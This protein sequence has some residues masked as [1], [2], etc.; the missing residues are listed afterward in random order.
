MVRIQYGSRTDA[1]L[2]Q[3]F[4]WQD[5]LIHPGDGLDWSKLDVDEAGECSYQQ[6]YLHF[7]RPTDGT[8]EDR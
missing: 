1:S 6:A 3:S 5:G 4:T 7:N 8:V 2:R